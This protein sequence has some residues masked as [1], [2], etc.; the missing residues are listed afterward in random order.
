MS[1]NCIVTQVHIPDYDVQGN[2]TAE[3]KLTLVSFGLQHLREFNPDAYIILTGHGHRP[4]NLEL[5]NHVEW[6]DSCLPL[7]ENGYVAGMPAQYKFVAS[8]L[9]HALKKGFSN[10]LKTRGDCI[11]GIPNIVTHCQQILEDEQRQLLITQQT[12]PERLGDCFMYGDAELLYRT[13]H[14]DNRVVNDDGLQNTAFHYRE[15]QAALNEDWYTL[16]RRTCA[17]RDVHK[18]KFMCLRWNFHR[19]QNLVL[20]MQQKLLDKAFPFEK[21]HWGVADNWHHFSATDEMTGT[22]TSWSWSQR[23][24][25]R[26]GQK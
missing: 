5:C 14:E 7:N 21:F 6:A 8:G 26:F 15:A 22:A 25:Y 11:I 16:I 10:V 20:E 1:S 24:F 19:L 13:W 12:G 9:K 2:L 4:K 17:F 3:Q 23:D 18:L